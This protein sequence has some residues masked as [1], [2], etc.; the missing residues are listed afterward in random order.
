M[1][2]ALSN[3]INAVMSYFNASPQQAIDCVSNLEII[4]PYGRVGYLRWQQHSPLVEFGNSDCDLTNVAGGIQT[5]TE[6]ANKGIIDDV[7]KLIGNAETLVFL[8]YGFLEQNNALLRVESSNVRRVFAT[9]YG[10]SETDVPIIKDEILKIVSKRE[11]K[12]LLHYQNKKFA[13]IFIERQYCRDLLDNH[14]FRLA[15][16]PLQV[17]E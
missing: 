4:H 8:G 2:V 16:E 6:S 17:I 9:T 5:F 14:R 13:E 15:Q 11:P 12:S 3:L 10:I 7:K 1:I